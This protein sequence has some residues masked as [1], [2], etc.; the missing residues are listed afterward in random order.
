MNAG[1]L[2]GKDLVEHGN[3]PRN[4]RKLVRA[5]VTF[6]RTNPACGDELRIS[7]TLENDKLTDV[8]F[9]GDGCLVSLASASMLTE[10]TRGKTR[11]E[12]LALAD[13]ARGY[14]GKLGDVPPSMP[15]LIAFAGLARFPVRRACARL[16]WDALASA[17]SQGS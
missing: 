14:L 11:T 1:D 7:A 12:A 3:H 17:L 16:A 4:R 9:E 13:A 8:V 6:F 15:D 5:D 2:Y 10:L